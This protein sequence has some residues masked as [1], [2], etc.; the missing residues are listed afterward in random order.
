M[1]AEIK[2]KWVEALRSGRYEQAQ[3]T[4]QRTGEEAGYCC[5]GVLCDV[6]A[7]DSWV[8]EDVQAVLF[9]TPGYG[10]MPSPSVY[11]ASGLTIADSE[12]LALKNDVQH[13][14][15]NEIADWIEENL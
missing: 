12:A 7:P 15:F 14:S 11:Q 3:G 5:L 9:H 6:V 13:L 2:Q 8:D 4:L 10:A 1:N